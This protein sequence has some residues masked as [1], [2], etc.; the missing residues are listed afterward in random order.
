ML[1]CTGLTADQNYSKAAEIL[2][3]AKCLQ[4]NGGFARI[5]HVQD[6]SDIATAI[7]NGEKLSDDKRAPYYIPQG[8]DSAS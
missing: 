7:S 3:R 8:L 4:L 1:I 2:L 5:H 6:V